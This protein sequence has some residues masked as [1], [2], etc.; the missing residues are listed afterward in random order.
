MS[1]ASFPPLGF[2]GFPSR[3]FLLALFSQP[4]A[5]GPSLPLF[6]PAGR[7]LEH[8]SPL[9]FAPNQTILCGLCILAHR[10]CV[11]QP[12][13]GEHLA[14]L[15]GFFAGGSNAFY[16]QMTGGTADGWKFLLGDML[17]GHKTEIHVECLTGWPCAADRR[18]IRQL[19]FPPIRSPATDPHLSESVGRYWG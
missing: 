7:F 19:F 6:A 12:R 2:G 10:F 5:F 3:F 17:F 16:H 13:F 18:F 8:G 1:L 14:G 9:G 11:V 15:V 4:V